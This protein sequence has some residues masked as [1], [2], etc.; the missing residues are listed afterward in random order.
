MGADVFDDYQLG[1]ERQGAVD[2]D[3]LIRLA[4]DAMDADRD[5]LARLRERWPYVLEDEAQDSSQ[6]QENIL[7]MLAGPAG[8]WVRVGDPNQAI[9][10]TFTNAN[11]RFLRIFWPRRRWRPARCP[12]RAVPAPASSS[13]P[14][15]WCTGRWQAT[16]W[17]AAR[18][19]LRLQDIRP[20]AARR[21]PAQ[22]ARRPRGRLPARQGLRPTRTRRRRADRRAAWP[23]GCPV[24][25]PDRGRPRARA[26]IAAWPWWTPC[27][28]RA[29]PTWSCCAARPHARRRR[30]LLGTVLDGL[31]QPDPAA[32]AGRLLQGLAASRG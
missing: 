29:S 9:Y 12:S 25:G 14:T 3:D 1:L 15:I 13:W 20:T 17:T 23:A 18:G 28:K 26:T 11:P 24:T 31:A 5:Y 19:A 7:R 21:P 27:P 2:F 30:V 4:L 10:D 22:P 6:L 8:N 16:P 32:G